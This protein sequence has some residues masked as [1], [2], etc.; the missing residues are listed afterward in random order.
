[1]K[2]H[3]M[4]LGKCKWNFGKRHNWFSSHLGRLTRQLTSKLVDRMSDVTSDLAPILN[5]AA[6]PS[7]VPPVVV[8][9]GPHLRASLWSRPTCNFAIPLCSFTLQFDFLNFIL[10][11]LSHWLLLFYGVLEWWGSATQG[12]ETGIHNPETCSGTGLIRLGVVRAVQRRG[13]VYHQRDR[14]IWGS[15][16]WLFWWQALNPLDHR[17]WTDIHI[18]LSR[19]FTLFSSSRDIPTWCMPFPCFFVWRSCLV[20]P[21]AN[22]PQ[23]N[24]STDSKHHT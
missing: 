8:S 3:R 13:T 2:N 18:R 17:L 4:K 9:G 19:D 11:C 5:Q 23:Q 1:M 7:T 12:G 14:R 24:P 15:N 20:N 22:K 16:L 21:E 10:K 6:S